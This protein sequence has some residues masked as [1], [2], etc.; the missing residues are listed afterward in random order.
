MD[1]G[2][3]PR[4]RLRRLPE[5]AAYDAE[6][7]F[8]ILDEARYC[9]VASVI[10][11]EA[12]LTPTLHW[13]D[14]SRVFFHGSPGNAVL[15]AMV[16]RGRGALSVTLYDGLR[17]ARSGF[18]SSIAFRSVVAYGTV[19]ELDHDEAKGALDRLVDAILPGRGEEVR[20]TSEREVRLTSVVA[21]DITEA[22]AKVS[23]GPTSDEPED[24]ALNI[25]SGVVPARITFA[26]PVPA[27]DGAMARG[28][29][30]V[31]PSVLR[32]L[33]REQ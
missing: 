19:R 11:D 24:A 8:A 29:V 22:S 16:A 33:A 21:L 1:L 27:R 30:V 6:T 12:A 20:A 32:L 4:T 9:Y 26:D 17:L 15:R 3:G 23:A 10:D 13:R 18:E 5:K 28:D 31:P 2:P 7:V 25:W 14:G